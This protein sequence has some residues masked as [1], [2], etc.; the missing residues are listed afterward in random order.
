MTSTETKMAAQTIGRH[1][2]RSLDV[3]IAFRSDI[4]RNRE[5]PSRNKELANSGI[6]R[7]KE[8]KDL[9]LRQDV[10]PAFVPVR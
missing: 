8:V 2:D 7:P 5:K 9:E 1:K 10:I 3:S 6:G 4:V